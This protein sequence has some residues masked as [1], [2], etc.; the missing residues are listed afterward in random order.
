MRMA[1][2]LKEEGQFDQA[3]H[4]FIEAGKASEAVAMYVREGDWS[5]AEQVAKE[6]TV[7]TLPD[8]LVAQA[9][10]SLENEDYHSAESCFLRANRPDIILK[11]YQENGMWPDALRIAKQYLPHQLQQLQKDIA[12]QKLFEN[13]SGINCLLAQGRAFEEQREWAKAVQTYLKV[14]SCSTKDA[15]L[16]EYSL[17]KS[18]DLI[19]RFPAS[20]DYELIMQVVDA[21]ETNKM[22][23][24][25]AE[26]LLG[27]GQGRQAVAALVRAHQWSKAK[28]LATELIPDM[29]V[30]VEEQYKKW[31]V[32]EG[33]M[34]ELIDVDVIAVIDL[35]IAKDQWERA[36]HLARQQNHKPLLDKYVAQYAAIL[37]EH[38]EL[39]HLLKIFEKYGTSSNPANFNLYKH[40]F[41]KTVSRSSSTSTGEFDALSPVRDLFLSVYEQLVKEESENQFIFERYVRALHLMTIRSALEDNIQTEDSKQLCLQQSIS[42]LRYSDLVPADRVF[43]QAGIS[44]RHAG[45]VYLP[46][47]F[48]LL[49]HYLDLVDAINEGDASLVDYAPF[50]GTD[51]PTEVPLPERPWVESSKHEEIEE[52]VLATSLGHEARRELK[53]D[54]RGLFEATIEANGKKW[55]ECIISGYPVTKTKVDLGNLRADKDNLNR[56][57]IAVRT[58]PTDQLINVQE[59]ISRWAN[60]P[61]FLSL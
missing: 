60:Q 27:V 43:Y 50:E 7:E 13:G 22:Y 48:L 16:I 53:Y 21:L 15:S 5:N 32:Q 9:L 14:S 11:F 38:N 23:E 58:T 46:L 18:T 8:V 54:S 34:G 28:Q 56:F 37:L 19:L 25:M 42:L 2:Q 52:W 45:R 40:I 33:R 24:K 30:E 1:L 61:L 29:V 3:A 47:A 59:F 39:D 20:I 36:L 41:K 44:A 12:Q 57:L 26:V 35:L 51:I 10:K 49:N 6:H 55:P 31:L 17:I 4:H